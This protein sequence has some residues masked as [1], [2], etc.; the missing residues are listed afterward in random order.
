MMQAMEKETG[1]KQ[2]KDLE[3]KLRGLKSAYAQ[4]ISRGGVPTEE[5]QRKADE[6]F[7]TKDPHTVLSTAIGAL[8]QE[9]KAVKKAP[10]MVRKELAESMM[11]DDSGDPDADDTDDT[12]PPPEIGEVVDGHRF[13]GGEPGDP[14][15]WEDE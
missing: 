13:K 10:G 7:A 6:L 5:A 14:N 11:G 1:N 4:V 8:K 2:L 9:I 12:P 3:T 15:N